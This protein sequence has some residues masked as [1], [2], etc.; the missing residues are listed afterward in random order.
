ML[1]FVCFDLCTLLT[2]YI[3][4]LTTFELRD[5]LSNTSGVGSE[6]EIHLD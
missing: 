2:F 6:L 4:E 3:F 5:T 1:T